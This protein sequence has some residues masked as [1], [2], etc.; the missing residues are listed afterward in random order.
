MKR[1]VPQ[2]E[3]SQR[4]LK[5]YATSEA[6]R[7]ADWDAYAEGWLDREKKF[8]NNKAVPNNPMMSGI[9]AFQRFGGE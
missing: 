5:L 3:E 9:A 4:R 6:L 1:T 8:Q 7:K 2:I